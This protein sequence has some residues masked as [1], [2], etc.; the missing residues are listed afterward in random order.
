MREPQSLAA[1]KA[2]IE[3]AA[4]LIS[5]SLHRWPRPAGCSAAAHQLPAR[6]TTRL[7]LV[8]LA[9]RL[10]EKAVER[11]ETPERAES[12]MLIPAWNGWEG[13]DSGSYKDCCQARSMVEGQA[14][15][16]EAGDL[17]GRGQWFNGGF[18]ASQICSTEHRVETHLVQQACAILCTRGWTGGGKQTLLLSWQQIILPSLFSS[19]VC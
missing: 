10:P 17:L 3:S 11:Q 5:C 2:R 6:I 16:F 1:C 19:A 15:A 14:I 8:A 12:C 4:A 9:T 7:P 13:Q 18:A